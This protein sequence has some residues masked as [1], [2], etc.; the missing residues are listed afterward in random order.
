MRVGDV[1]YLKEGDLFVLRQSK[2]KDT[3]GITVNKSVAAALDAWLSVHPDKREDAPLFP[4]RK[5]GAITVGWM[6]RMVKAWC[7]DVGLRGNYST[8]TMRK[9]WGYHQRVQLGTH[10]SLL[11]KAYG[12]ATEAQT[13]QYL[14]IQEDEIKDL[15]GSLE[16]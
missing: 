2:T 9:T 7:A 4:S 15:Y 3:R 14:C 5:G 6:G 16:L 10:L 1:D 11:T 13:L 8:H 12:H